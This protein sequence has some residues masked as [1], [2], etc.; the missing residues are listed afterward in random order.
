MEAPHVKELGSR[1]LLVTFIII[2]CLMYG[3]VYEYPSSLS[4]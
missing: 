3:Q 1:F 2:R 4:Y